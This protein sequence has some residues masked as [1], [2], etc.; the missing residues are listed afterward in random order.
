MLRDLAHRGLAVTRRPVGPATR[1]THSPTR[2][3]PSAALEPE[4]YAPS[5]DDEWQS[6]LVVAAVDDKRGGE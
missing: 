5:G 3:P 6:A 2:M 1:Q 4:A